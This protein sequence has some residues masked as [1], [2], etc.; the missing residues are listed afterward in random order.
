[1]TDLFIKNFNIIIERW[2]ALASFLKEQPIDHL[3]AKLITG[4]VQTISVNGIQL[5]SRHDRV[6]ETKLLINSLHE[7]ARNISVY[8]IGM[9]DLPSFLIDNIKIENINVYILNFSLFKL[10]LSYTDQTE[11][12]ESPKITLLEPHK[13]LELAKF[14]LSSTPDLSLCEDKYARIRDL[15]IYDKNFEFVNEK[16][17]KRQPEIETRFKHNFQHLQDDP[18]IDE[19]KS[20]YRKKTAIII[21]SGPTLEKQYNFLIQIQQLEESEKPLIIAV[22]TALKALS[23]K[24]VIPDIVVTLDFFIS[25]THFPSKIP[26]SISLVYFPTTSIDVIKK[27]PGPRFNAFQK[28]KKYNTK[29]KKSQLYTSGSVIHPTIDLAVNLNVKEIFLLGCDFCYPG[30]KTHAYWGDGE[31]GPSVKFD[32][33]HWVLNGKGERVAT[34]LNFRS[35]LRSLETY[36]S[37]KSDVTFYQSSLESAQIN[38]VGYKELSI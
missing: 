4:K 7:M 32:K 35:Y 14:Y 37:T 22:D 23:S 17:K 2:P 30:N 24:K 16:H 20:I 8:G 11:W 9:G 18:D 1:M 13:S 15:V 28:G 3:D 36:I 5:S 29:L 26:Q 21:A 38:G 19:L 27:W 31:L 10:L 34:D 12:L 25:N 33:H 6:K